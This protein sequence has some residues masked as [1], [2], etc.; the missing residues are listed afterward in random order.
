MD[1]LR[2][3]DRLHPAFGVDLR[4]SRVADGPQQNDA[5]PPDAEEWSDDE[6]AP[7]DWTSPSQLWQV[8]TILLSL[9]LIAV[10]VI[11][12]IQRAPDD[13]FGAAMAEV[14]I[15]IGDGKL[16][17]AGR[18]LRDVL[19]PNLELAT[20]EERGRFHRAVAD[21]TSLAQREAGASLPENNERID[22]Q[23]ALA[24]EFGV[25][26]DA[27]RLE[28]WAMSRIGLGQLDAAERLLDELDHLDVSGAA[29]AARNARIRVFRRLVEARLR[30][31][32]YDRSTVEQKLAEFRT[33]QRSTLPD[34]AWAISR[35]AEIRLGFGEP[36][37]AVDQLLVDLRRLEYEASDDS[38]V[39]FGELNA[40]LGRGYYDLGRFDDAEFHLTRSMDMFESDEPA[41]GDAL[42]VLGRLAVVR[43]DLELAYGFFDPVVRDFVGTPSFLP[44]LLGRAEVNSQ[45][46]NH[47]DSR[48]DY[49]ELRRRL[50]NQ[51]GDRFVT[52][53][54]VAASLVDRH[55]AALAL[56]QL[57]LAI[58]YAEI[59]EE[60]FQPNAVP[61]DV[62][63][64]LASSSRQLA[65]NIMAEAAGDQSGAATRTPSIDPAKRY[66]ANVKYEKAGEYF[67]R[68]ARAVAAN[69]VEDESWAE[70]LWL[71]GQS[72]DRAGLHEEAIRHLDEYLSGRSRED[73][74][75]GEVAFRLAQAHHALQQYEDAARYYELV[76][77]E[78][79]R[80]VVATRAHV[81]LARCYLALER[82]PE[83]E[84][85]LR[86][87]LSGV[88]PIQP[89][90]D[91]FR[92]ALIELGTLYYRTGEYTDAVE[93]LDQATRRY[94][95]DPGIHQIMYRLADSYRGLARDIEHRL[96]DE[97][98]ESLGEQRRLE[99]LRFDHLREAM[100]LYSQVRE[101][102]ENRPTE[103]LSALDEDLLRSS[104]LL[105]AEAAFEL[106]LF[107]QAIR[108]YDLTVRR[109]PDHHVS[110]HALIQVVNA[111]MAM[112]DRDRAQTA[113]KRALTHLQQLRDEAFDAPDALLDRAA[114]EQWL[115]N[116]PVAARTAR[117][118]DQRPE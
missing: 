72:F 14:E 105:R 36:Q 66:Q 7:V 18:R 69:P 82:K 39:N 106:G 40:L 47:E 10:G 34:R 53:E 91:D 5:P 111:Y 94:P 43:G 49:R 28:R 20:N 9:A 48:H 29:S 76:I 52:K 44:G 55:D 83:A 16:E 22:E 115:R 59:A 32:D 80:S 4:G 42:V 68:H 62:L 110:M 26:M 104:H 107:D 75:R 30:Q 97:R 37:R 100:A 19:E 65:D 109:Y 64:R 86:Q 12:A 77:D 81:P 85:Q 1:S 23:Y 74:R 50:R 56:G 3:G 60:L 13:D 79:P 57:E 58:A 2:F 87:V 101:K 88:A 73:P 99:E 98:I 70:S 15:W 61:I 41:R 78:Q 114:W 84:R 108:W 67:V 51:E 21:W 90:A 102:L 25:P 117:A 113:H 112:G 46:G 103:R 116:T 63:L 38:R 45:L 27:V 93:Y 35:L 33:D 11:V 24:R 96:R 54:R 17:Q 71:A 89:D 31:P 118:G 6:S 8:P 95:D 92:D